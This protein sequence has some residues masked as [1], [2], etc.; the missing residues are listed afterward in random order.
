MELNGKIEKIN[1]R[2]KLNVHM[3]LLSV[4]NIKINNIS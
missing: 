1:E 2:L 4:Q 3:F